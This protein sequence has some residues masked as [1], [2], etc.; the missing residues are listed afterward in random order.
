MLNASF[1]TDEEE[2]TIHDEVD[3]NLLQPSFSDNNS[4]EETVFDAVLTGG[5]VSEYDMYYSSDL[6]EPYDFM[7]SSQNLSG[8]L[9]CS[10]YD[11]FVTANYDPDMP[12]NETAKDMSELTNA[13]I[14]T[15]NIG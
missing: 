1:S 14:P 4:N 2:F 6:E 15:S 3:M 9:Q 12:Y 13:T 8:T 10:N 7:S 11:V 5:S